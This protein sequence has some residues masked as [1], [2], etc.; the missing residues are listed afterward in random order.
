MHLRL[1]LI[2]SVALVLSATGGHL[3][4]AQL[5]PGP[6]FGTSSGGGSGGTPTGPTNPGTLGFGTSSAGG[7]GGVPTGPLNQNAYGF[8]SS[9]AGGSGGIPT[10][11][12]V[13]GLQLTSPNPGTISPDLRIMNDPSFEGP[14]YATPHPKRTAGRSRHRHLAR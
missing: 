5:N 12:T 3:A 2:L 13:P 10:G 8:G 6:T 11:P 14:V 4:Q 9:T 7:S 1:P